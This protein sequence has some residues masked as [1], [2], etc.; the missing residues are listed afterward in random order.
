MAAKGKLLVVQVAALGYGL[1]KGAEIAGLTFRPLE[2]A[3]PAVT[4]TAQASFRTAATPGL[5]GMVG[6]GFYFREL[7]RPMFWE[8]SANLVAGERIWKAFRE[9]GRRVG[10]MFLSLIHI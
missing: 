2:A 8:Q 5:H 1:T 3:F 10:I 9:R 4:C 7:S 6:N